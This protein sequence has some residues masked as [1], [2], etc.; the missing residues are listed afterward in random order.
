MRSRF[1]AVCA[2]LVA[3]LSACGSAPKR[4][5]NP[6]QQLAQLRSSNGS[7]TEQQREV[8]RCMSRSGFKYVP[9]P[10]RKTRPPVLRG[11]RD[12]DTLRRNFYGLR[13]GSGGF[14]Y[15]FINPNTPIYLQLSA[16]NQLVYNRTLYGKDRSTGSD[17]CY[18]EAMTR[19][20]SSRLTRLLTENGNR[21]D[22]DPEVRQLLRKWS[23]CMKAKS[24]DIS[25]PVDLPSSFLVPIVQ[26]GMRSDGTFKIRIEDEQLEKNLANADADCYQPILHRISTVES[27]YARDTLEKVNEPVP[28]TPSNR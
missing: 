5:T 23:Q 2:T 6:S 14:G 25:S 24:F 1:G 12:L 3:L 8:E 18:G 19:T 9:I 16:E 7:W 20:T 11:A 17:G 28:T 13:D 4:T 27:R 15:T 10:A 26:R 22:Q 21:F